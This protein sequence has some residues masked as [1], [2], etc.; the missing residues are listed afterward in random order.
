MTINF[1]PT[2]LVFISSV[3][4]ECKPFRE[5]ATS[6]ALRS[7]FLPIRM[8]TWSAEARNSY[9]ACKRHLSECNVMI[10]I[11]TERYGSIHPE[12]GKSYTEMEYDASLELGIP[13]LAFLSE[14][15][16]LPTD[17]LDLKDLEKAKKFRERLGTSIQ[18]RFNT[19]DHL[20]LLVHQSLQEWLNDLIKTSLK[21]D[22]ESKTV[23]KE[24]NIGGEKASLDISAFQRLQEIINSDWIRDFDYVQ[25]NIPQYVRKEIRDN[26]IDYCYASD[27]P[28]NEFFNKNIIDIHNK[29]IHSINL[30]LNGISEVTTS[31]NYSDDALII[32][33]K[34]SDWIADYDKQYNREIKIIT[35]RGESIIE[36]Y[37]NFIRV[38]RQEGIFK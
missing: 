31:R 26:L 20:E 19:A 14:H 15:P 36:A 24:A 18:G 17:K 8:E 27:K 5:S 35:D 37:R 34:A 29:F 3:G 33:A 23:I 21:H 6:A 2:P 10:L 11:L 12:S 22:H 25:L 9:E 38:C 4:E 13:V 16:Y 28:E 7:R 30:F 32:K 1:R